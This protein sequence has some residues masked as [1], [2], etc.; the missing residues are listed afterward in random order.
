MNNMNFSISEIIAIV[1]NKIE[2]NEAVLLYGI[3]D[4]ENDLPISIEK[5]IENMSSERLIDFKEKIEEI[6]E[7]VLLIKTGELNE[8][9][10]CHEEIMILSHEMLEDYLEED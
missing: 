4:F 9:N 6:A 5:K 3:N 7:E 2:E 8:L 10:R 1:M